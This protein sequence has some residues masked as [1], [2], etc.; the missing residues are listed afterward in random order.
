[1]TTNKI[2]AML[3]AG[4]LSP[5]AGAAETM[6]IPAPCFESKQVV[7]LLNKSKAKKVA[8]EMTQEKNFVIIDSVWY[9]K[10]SILVLKEFK[11]QGITCILAIIN[12]KPQL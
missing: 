5:L 9:D 8:S 1:M 10:A 2:L 3:F 12:H 4:L 11:K 7:G 6:D